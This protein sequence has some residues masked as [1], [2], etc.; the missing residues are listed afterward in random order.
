MEALA[1]IAGDLVA[2]AAAGVCCGLAGAV[3]RRLGAL[4]L[5][6][7]AAATMLTISG[8]LDP[9]RRMLLDLR[10]NSAFAVALTAH[11]GLAEYP[12]RLFI[13]HK[14]ARV[15]M[16]GLAVDESE[17]QA[18]LEEIA[19]AA[20][21]YRIERD[22]KLVV[23]ESENQ[24]VVAKLQAALAET[25]A[26]VEALRAQAGGAGAPAERRSSTSRAE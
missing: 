2:A 17:A 9:L 11:P 5:L 20:L 16:R 3:R 8:G 4:V 25:K 10:I 15:V 7:A 24:R 23:L 26:A 19:P 13:D 22:L 18:V 12:T 1:P 14:A 6:F 21:P